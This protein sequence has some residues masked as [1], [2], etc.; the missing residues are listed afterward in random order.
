[1]DHKEFGYRFYYKYEQDEDKDAAIQALASH[2]SYQEVTEENY[3]TVLKSMFG[4]HW[5]E[6]L[7]KGWKKVMRQCQFSFGPFPSYTKRSECQRPQRCRQLGSRGSSYNES[8]AETL[9]DS[10]V[11]VK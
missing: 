4:D 8:A 2:Y 6:E 11:S 3:E 5:T 10:N 7:K 9:T 1:M